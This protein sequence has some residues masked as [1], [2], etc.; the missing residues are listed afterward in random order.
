M[1]AAPAPVRPRPPQPA[2]RL[3]WPDGSATAFFYNY[4]RQQQ[5][6][7]QSLEARIKHLEP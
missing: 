6:Y 5:L 3:V 4:L 1:T 7:I 2:D